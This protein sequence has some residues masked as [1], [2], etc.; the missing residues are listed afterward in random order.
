MTFVFSFSSQYVYI[1]HLQKLRVELEER[2]AWL[3][4]QEKEMQQRDAENNRLVEE[5]RRCQ[6][7]LLNQQVISLVSPA[8]YANFRQNNCIAQEGGGAVGAEPSQWHEGQE[9]KQVCMISLC[10][11]AFYECDCCM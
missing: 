2:E 5:L 10:H 4:A 9:I 7:R 8:Y 6:A 11:V 3:R 1:P